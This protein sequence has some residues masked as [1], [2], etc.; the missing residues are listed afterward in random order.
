M[1]IDVERAAYFE[2]QVDLALAAG[3][4]T[5]TPPSRHV[6]ACGDCRCLQVPRHCAV[7][8]LRQCVQG[9]QRFDRSDYVAWKQAHQC[10][11]DARELRIALTEI[12]RAVQVLEKKTSGTGIARMIQQIEIGFCKARLLKALDL[13]NS[14]GKCRIGG[15]RSAF[16]AHGAQVLQDRFAA[17]IHVGYAG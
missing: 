4:L 16:H 8:P 5:S 9:R 3:M 10:R 14:L 12:A 13:R 6:V 7:K 11:S 2:H 1:G 17:S 15:A